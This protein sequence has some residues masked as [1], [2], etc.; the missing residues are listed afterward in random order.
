M[1]DKEPLT[2]FDMNLSAQE[3]QVSDM[4]CIKYCV[5]ACVWMHV[6]VGTWFMSHLVGDLCL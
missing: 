2:F 6:R 4:V 5:C 3:H 1:M